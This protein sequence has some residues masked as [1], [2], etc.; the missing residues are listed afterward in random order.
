MTTTY[1]NRKAMLA[2]NFYADVIEV[3]I[4]GRLVLSVELCD[5]GIRRGQTVTPWSEIFAA[6]IDGNDDLSAI[7]LHLAREGV[8]RGYAQRPCVEQRHDGDMKCG[9]RWTELVVDDVTI[10]YGPSVRKGNGKLGGVDT[11]DGSPLNKLANL[12]E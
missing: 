4:D 7:Y 10:V 12:F 1:T 11:M 3:R 6:A 9:E 8:R 5:D 2:T